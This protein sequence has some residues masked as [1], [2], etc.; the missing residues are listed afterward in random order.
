M[1]VIAG[2]GRE[3]QG[4]AVRRDGWHGIGGRVDTAHQAAAGLH[5]EEVVAIARLPRGIVPPHHFLADRGDGGLVETRVDA[6]VAERAEEALDVLVQLEEPP[7]ERARGI[8][9]RVAP[10]EPAVEHR[11]L[12]VLL[13]QVLDGQLAEFGG[14]HP[15]RRVGPGC[16]GQPPVDLDAQRFRPPPGLT[17]PFSSPIRPPPPAIFR[18]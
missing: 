2:V 1:T 16:G 11:D 15:V 10:P 8:V 13:G 17:T 5:R 9:H 14:R 6:R 18:S 12:R 3:G 4:Q 7:L